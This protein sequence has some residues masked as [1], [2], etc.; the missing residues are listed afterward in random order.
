MLQRLSA[1][2][3]ML[4]FHTF[5]PDLA[6]NDFNGGGDWVTMTLTTNLVESIGRPIIARQPSG[7]T[8]FDGVA[9][10]LNV[11]LTSGANVYY[12]WW[13]DGVCLTNNGRLNGANAATL[14]FSPLFAN[15]AG[16]YSVVV[17]NAYG[18]QTSVV[19]TLTVVHPPF[20]LL[21]LTLATGVG[22]RQVTFGMQSQPARTYQLLAR[23]DLTLG[24]WLPE[25]LPIS[26][27]GEVLLFNLDL[28]TNTQRYYRVQQV[29]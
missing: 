1:D 28:G 23:P 10:G 24:A 29:P 15:D 7:Q 14:T 25:G 11:G 12:Q 19:A 21:G 13:K 4:V 17:S 8:N 3:R 6:A 20:A 5:A 9:M 26:A 18:C 27:T 22:G 16:G 2:G